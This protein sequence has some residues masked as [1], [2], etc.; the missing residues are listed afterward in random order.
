MLESDVLLTE[1]LLNPGM[2]HLMLVEVLFPEWQ[3]PLGSRIRGDANL[4]GPL[5]ANLLAIRKGCHH[6]SRF[7]IGIGI[8]QVVDRDGAIHQHSLLYHA[9][10]NNLR[11]EVNVLLRSTRTRGDM[12]DAR[13]VVFHLCLQYS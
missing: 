8:I 4:T 9:Q 7:S 10:A 11:E 5:A 6:R 3:R 12:V 13:Y 1:A 2:L